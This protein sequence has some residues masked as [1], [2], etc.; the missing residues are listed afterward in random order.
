M[1]HQILFLGPQGS[2]KGTQATIL[3]ETLGVPALSMGQLLRDE[4]ASG[5][6]LGKTIADIIDRGDLV[7]D[8]MTTAVLKKRLE[9]EDVQKGFIIDSFPRYM[10]QYENSKDF[11][12]PTAVIAL[13]I[14]YEESISRLL[15]RAEIEGRADDTREKIEHRLDLYKKETEPVIETYNELGVAHV[16]D[17]VGT[18][19][20][21]QA[22]ILDALQ[23]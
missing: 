14:P 5:S 8:D 21:V 22:R 13:H 3:A 19:E 18:I 9:A 23:I 7:P 1:K 4:K 11:F 12:Q 2:G 16:V 15:K 10:E 20:E 17:G 6:D